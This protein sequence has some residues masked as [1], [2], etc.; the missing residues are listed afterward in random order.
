MIPQ[1]N[2]VLSRRERMLLEETIIP[3]PNS[4]DLERS[5]ESDYLY[6]LSSNTPHPAELFH[7]NS[8]LTPFSTLTIPSDDQKLQE[9][10]KWFFS[11]AYSMK[12]EDI[13]QAEAHRFRSKISELPASLVNLLMTF[14]QPG[15]VTNLLF[16][17]DLLLLQNQRL[18]RIVAESDYLFIERDVKA[19]N[20]QDFKSAV[21]DMP[22]VELDRFA[23]F[24]FMVVCPWRYMMLYGPR[25][26]RHTLLDAGRL[27]A[28]LEN[29][30][31]QHK[32]RLVVNQNFYD[33]QVDRFLFMDGVERSTLAVLAIKEEE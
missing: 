18:F 28:Y 25:G 30:A 11:T 8:K 13:N 24:L 3:S 29:A 31:Q 2:S 33:S 7:E 14:T 32:L 16:A 9:I 1:G 12:E 15:P 17:L 20:V 5:T 21:I 26:Y 27:L 22:R 23:S 4:I 10:R 19:S 6:R